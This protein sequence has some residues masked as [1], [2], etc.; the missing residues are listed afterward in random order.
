[1]QGRVDRGSIGGRLGR[2]IL[3]EVEK[4]FD[5]WGEVRDG[6]LERAVFQQNMLSVRA[7]VERLLLAGSTTAKKKTAG[8]CTEILKLKVALWTFVD[9]EGVEPTNNVGERAIRPA[10]MWRKG[11]LGTDSEQGSRFEE[12]IL[13]TVAT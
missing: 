10:V 4:M 7:T 3:D 1:M 2:Q 13:T 8:M 6:K 9:H 11:C 5:W 12:R